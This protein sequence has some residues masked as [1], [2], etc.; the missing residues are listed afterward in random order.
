MEEK[1]RAERQK[2]Q[3][4]H[5][6][7]KVTK[8]SG[9]KKIGKMYCRHAAEARI[10]FDLRCGSQEP[11]QIP[12]CAGM[13]SKKKARLSRSIARAT[14]GRITKESVSFLLFFVSFVP[15]W[16]SFRIFV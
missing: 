7:T 5:E 6:G 13:T 3:D 10:P 4:C 16:C 15:S 1:V 8:K 2:R 12:A 11:G 14:Q 9:N